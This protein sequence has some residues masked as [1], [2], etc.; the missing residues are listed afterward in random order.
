MSALVF[1]VQALLGLYVLTYLLRFALQ[2]VRA[3]FHNPLSQFIIR[4]TNPLVLPLRRVVPG[5][6]GFDLATFVAVL[7][8][9]ALTIVILFTL[10]GLRLPDPLVFLKLLAL[11]TL[12]DTVKLYF[13]AIIIVVIF[14]WIGQG[15]YNPAITALSRV[16]EPVLR[17][18]RRILPTIGG[19]DLSPLIVLIGLQA[20]LIL[21]REG[22][23][24]F[25]GW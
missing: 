5:W 19:L 13:Y 14:S 16:T 24:S 18:V 22:L 9:E 2:V 4:I 1:V 3:E 20:L 10:V 23:P 7:L 8:L 11:R 6:R 12:S 15:N 25:L 21:I 17:P